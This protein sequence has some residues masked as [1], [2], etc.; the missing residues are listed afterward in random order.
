MNINFAD[1]WPYRLFF[2]S[3]TSAS[4]TNEAILSSLSCCKSEKRGYRKFSQGM[5]ANSFGGLTAHDGRES[6]VYMRSVTEK[7]RMYDSVGRA[8][9]RLAAGDLVTTS[10]TIR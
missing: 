10:G 8:L 3:G 6:D 2:M 5:T 7:Y 4:D 1:N 9:W